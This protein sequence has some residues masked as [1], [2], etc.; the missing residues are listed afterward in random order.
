MAAERKQQC[1]SHKGDAACQVAQLQQSC[2]WHWADV[3]HVYGKVSG[4]LKQRCRR[5]A[6]SC[7]QVAT[8]V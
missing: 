1:A 8:A 7:K 6:D 5:N 2:A 3:H 4:F